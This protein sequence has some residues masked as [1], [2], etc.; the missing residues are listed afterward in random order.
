MLLSDVENMVRLD[1]FDPAGTNQRWATSDIDRAIDKAVDRYSEYYPNVAYADMQSETYQRTY[2]Y[3]TSWNTAYP[4]QW[5][6]RILYPLQVYGSCYPAPA[7]AP[8]T[9]TQAGSTTAIGSY[10]Y[11]VTLITQ[12]GETTPS[13]SASVV[14]TSGNQ[15]VQLSSI[16]VSA[17]LPAQPGTA[18]NTVIGRNIY[19]TLVGGSIFYLLA[20]LTDNTTTVYNDSQPDS[21]LSSLPTP[22]RAPTVNTSGVMCW[23]PQERPFS[24]FSNL[25][26]STASLAASGNLGPQGISGSAAGPTGTQAPTFTLQVPASAL[27][28]DKT[29]LMRV[30]YATKHQLDSNGSTIPEL[31]RDIVVLG[32]CAY[33]MEAYQVPTNDNFDLQDG[34]LHDRLDDTK[35]PLAWSSAAQNRMQQFFKRLQELRQQRDYAFASYVQWGN[36]PRYWDRL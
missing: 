15:S 29:L 9:V 34:S 3:P 30:F 20:T 2:P 32:A 36:V 26:D 25:F 6:E 22:P 28:Q 18:T 12:G 21:M 31:H 10:Q 17:S 5:I 14:T 13:P 23:P 16:P 4:V 35:I 7:S 8:V 1:L 11:A 19:R 24:E 33:A 27:P